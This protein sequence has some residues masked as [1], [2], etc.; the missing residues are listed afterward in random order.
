MKF[1]NCPLLFLF[2]HAMEV[3]FVDCTKDCRLHGRRTGVGGQRNAVY[4]LSRKRE[5]TSSAMSPTPAGGPL[6]VHVSFRRRPWAFL[7]ILCFGYDYS[8]QEG[9]GPLDL[10]QQGL[11]EIGMWCSMTSI[12]LESMCILPRIA[13]LVTS[14][15][16]VASKWPHNLNFALNLKSATSI[17]L[18]SLCIL[19]QTAILVASEAMAASKQPRRSYLASKWNSV[20][21]ITHVAILIW[22]LKAFIR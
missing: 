16:M 10:R 17:T 11:W 13:I 1:A 15:A 14:E 6:M 4:P 19:P 18:I 9:N 2:L 21:S 3:A 20:T 8:Q 22:P 7:R 12:T 5:C